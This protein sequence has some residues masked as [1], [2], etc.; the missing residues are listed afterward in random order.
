MSTAYEQIEDLAEDNE[1]ASTLKAQEII[2]AALTEGMTRTPELTKAVSTVSRSLYET[3]DSHEEGVDALRFELKHNGPK[4]AAALLEDFDGSDAVQ[5]VHL[6][7][8]AEEADGDFA[9]LHENLT[10]NSPVARRLGVEL[11]RLGHHTKNS[12]KI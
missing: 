10:A 4:A 8:I 6:V 12:R 2:L 11:R 3:A 9:A 1:R 5:R 7:L